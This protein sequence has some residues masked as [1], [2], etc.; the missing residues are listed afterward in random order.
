VSLGLSA[1]AAVA[2]EL[3]A[4][5]RRVYRLSQ[6]IGQGGLRLERPAPFEPGRPVAIRFTLPGGA[7]PLELNAEVVATGD[8]AEEQGE[9]G[10]LALHFRELAPETRSAIGAYIADRLDLPPLPS[11]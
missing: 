10:G 7:T 2:V 4:G 5:A 3:R 8:P 1:P 6:E 9:R 11:I